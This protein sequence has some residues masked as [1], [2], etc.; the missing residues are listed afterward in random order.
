M[1]RGRTRRS[2]S[3]GRCRGHARVDV[4]HEGFVRAGN[5]SLRGTDDKETMRRDKSTGSGVACIL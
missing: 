1:T 2:A 3:S 5:A 4:F